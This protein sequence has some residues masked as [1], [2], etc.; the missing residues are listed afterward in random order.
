MPIYIFVCIHHC[1]ADRL[2]VT[3]STTQKEKKKQRH[4]T[5]Y[6][7]LYV[8]DGNHGNASIWI[9]LILLR[10]NTL[11]PRYMHLLSISSGCSR[12]HK[13]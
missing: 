2:D 12:E 11:I 6:N 9:V 3:A 8:N 1:Q 7:P 5:G 4:Q 10:T 13:N